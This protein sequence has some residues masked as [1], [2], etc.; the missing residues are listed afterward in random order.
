MMAGRAAHLARRGGSPMRA[1]GCARKLATMRTHL[2]A[3]LATLAA[4]G[5]AAA[6]AAA[7][8][9]VF[10]K[11]HNVWSADVDG[12]SPHQITRDGTS[13]DPYSS[14]SQDD[15]GSIAVARNVA[16]LRLDRNG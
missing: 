3:G 12:S 16:I 4:A 8:S 13:G 11:D 10:I 9:I 2:L 7:D 14:P 15:R 1:P 5:A 6:P